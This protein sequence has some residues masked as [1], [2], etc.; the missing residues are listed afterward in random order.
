MRF[1]TEAENRKNVVKAMEE[2]LNIKAK[3]LGPPTFGYEVGSFTV[4]RDG[5]VDTDSEEEGARM[6]E[7]LIKRGLAYK[8]SDKLNIGIPLE[9]FTAE[10]MKNL[11]NM[12]HSKQYLLEKA[13]GTTVLKVSD[14]LVERLT[15]EADASLEKIVEII[16]KEETVGLD[17][18]ADR[19]I[20]C[21][22]P[23]SEEATNAYCQLV[24]NMVKTANEQKRISPQETIEENEKYYMRIWLVRLGFDGKEGKEVRNILL[25]KLKGHTAFR[26]EADKEKWKERYGK[27][28]EVKADE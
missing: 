14:S 9:K 22:F 8:E 4:D 25:S 27:A 18:S 3:Y 20:F 16:I 6:H 1:K 5:N 7:E 10:G 11:I 2:V 26:T 12:I 28:K 23:L 19:V 17:F 13:V 21:G 24:A 15:L